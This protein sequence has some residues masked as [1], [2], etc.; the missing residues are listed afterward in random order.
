MK[1]QG[2]HHVSLNVANAVEAERFYLDVLGLELLDRPDFGFPGSWLGLP[3]GRQVHLIEV[4]DWTGPK[5][6]HFAF[7]VTDL[8]EVRA[9]LTGKGLKV[10]EPSVIPGVGRQSFFK[11][12]CG[13][14]LELNEPVH[15]G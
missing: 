3:D 11:D 10:S 5:G 14:L 7:K 13:N 6:Q 8:D 9:E 4:A 15:A 2:V 1:L 12:P